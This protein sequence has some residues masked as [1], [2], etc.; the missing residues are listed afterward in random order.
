MEL[1]KRTLRWKELVEKELARAGT[2]LPVELVLAIIRIES[3]GEP[4]VMNP[5]SGASGLMQ[6][7]PIVVKDYNK[8]HAVKYSIEDMRNTANP[9]AQ[10]RVGIWCLGQFW[11]SAYRYLLK[12][13]GT[14]DT[15][16]LMKVADLFYAAGPGATKK[17]FRGVS[18]PTFAALAAAHPTW[19]ALP[20]T[21]KL[22]D[23]V[24][25]SKAPF[26]LDAISDWLHTVGTRVQR[27]QKTITGAVVAMLL[28]GAA[29]WYMG[30]GGKGGSRHD[31]QEKIFE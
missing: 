27:Q 16:E 6:V 17:K 21:R 30:Q 11:R 26:N 5:K 1:N 19:N 28:L 10:I 25:G 12:R 18:P 13:A 7:M 23:L 24:S 31:K 14:V 9:T 2:P 15:A 4:G 20:H 3:N 29:Y 8:Q 22:T